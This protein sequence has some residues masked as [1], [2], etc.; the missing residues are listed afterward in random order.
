[1]RGGSAAAR[2]GSVDG[3]KVTLENFEERRGARI[4]SPH[5]LLAMRRFGVVQEDIQPK[6]EE[7]EEAWEDCLPGG[8]EGEEDEEVWEDFLPDGLQVM[9]GGAQERLSLKESEAKRMLRT[10]SVTSGGSA[11][12]DPT[13]LRA[14][15]DP[16]KLRDMRRDFEERTRQRLIA[17][18][19]A[20]RERH[21][22]ARAV[23]ITDSTHTE[24]CV[25]DGVP[26]EL[27]AYGAAARA[28]YIT[29]PFGLDGQKS[30]KARGSTSYNEEMA[31]VSIEKGRQK[32]QRLHHM[33]RKRMQAM[34]KSQIHIHDQMHDLEE[35]LAEKVNNSKQKTEERRT[36]IIME[37]QQRME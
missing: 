10:S 16:L 4:D 11:P 30:S 27:K 12:V 3:G 35:R 29:E 17:K 19:L 37:R 8:L 22:K 15:A 1:M 6:G 26:P 36:S 23:L 5:S 13:A 20:E 24:A 28:A 31:A 14:S 18:L 2:S 25:E 7:D 34:V 33:E 21:R 32:V 9:Y